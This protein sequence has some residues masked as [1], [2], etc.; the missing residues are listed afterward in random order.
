MVS[1]DAG[2]WKE[3]MQMKNAANDRIKEYRTVYA[4]MSREEFSARTGIDPERLERLEEG[5]TSAKPEDVMAVSRAFNISA[6]FL[7]GQCR[8][9]KPAVRDQAAEETWAKLEQ[10]SD[11]QLAELG[12]I[13]EKEA[14][15]PSD[16]E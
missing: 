12:R 10:M 13:L 6:D 2:G 5:M 4:D 7:T 3:R 9:P 16:G 8:L 11:E 14:G 1:T 15:N